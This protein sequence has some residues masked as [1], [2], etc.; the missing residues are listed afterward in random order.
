MPSVMVWMLVSPQSLY[1][2]ILTL[3]MVVLGC[4]SFWEVSRS[5]GSAF[6]VCI[7]SL[8]KEV[9]ENLLI[10]S[11]I[12]GH[13]KKAVCVNQEAGFVLDS[14]SASALILYSQPPKLWEV[15]FCYL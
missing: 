13:N 7:S 9:P 8:I 2:E 3:K 1:V 4:W 12:W 15:S 6:M 14:K 10:F 5:W 11:T